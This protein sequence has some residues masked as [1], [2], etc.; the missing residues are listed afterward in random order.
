M[1]S[2]KG[3]ELKLS[4]RNI[5]RSELSELLG[6]SSR[7]IA[8]IGKGEKLSRGIMEK[9]AAFFG[10]ATEELCREIS[11]NPILQTL[12]EEKDAR[13]SFRREHLL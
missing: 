8:K 3:L 6:I 12:R 10:C 7:T 1:Y 5:G 2:Y 9:L 13:L 11:D 4:E